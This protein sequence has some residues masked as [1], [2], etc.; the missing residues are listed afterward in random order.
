MRREGRPTGDV[1]GFERA[2]GKHIESLWRQQSEAS[3]D[4]RGQ[5]MGDERQLTLE[6]NSRLHDSSHPN[7]W[8]GVNR[9]L[10]TGHLPL[11]WHG[12][13]SILYYP[14]RE[15]HPSYRTQTHSRCGPHP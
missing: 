15:I 13:Q 12:D 14:Q 8:A 10:L 6:S 5:K 4:T 2:L 3:W 7:R 11:L 9:L 1:A